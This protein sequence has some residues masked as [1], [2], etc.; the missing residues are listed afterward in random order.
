MERRFVLPNTFV[1]FDLEYT[2]WEGSYVRNWSGE[3]EHREVIQVGAILVSGRQMT[4]ETSMLTYVKP[5]RNPQL[6]EFITSFTGITQEDVNARGVSFDT[7]LRMLCDFIRDFPVFCWG[8]DIEVLKENCQ[9]N[10]LPIPGC[11]SNMAN[12]KPILTP[13]FTSRGVDVSRY[14]SGTL[15]SFFTGVPEARRAHDALNDMRNFRDAL[16]ELRKTDDV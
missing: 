9:L 15:I 5:S 6:S 3:N 11:F 7:A 10:A 14:T 1:L 2:A 13:A 16:Q 4:E 12:L 8:K